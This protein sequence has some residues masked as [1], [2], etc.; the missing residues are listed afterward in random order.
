MATIGEGR[1][2]RVCDA[3]GGVDD[4][5]RHALM[6]G[7]FPDPSPE[8]VG[9]VVDNAP[10]DQRNRL[11][12]ELMDTTAIDLHLDCC[13]DRGCPTGQCGARTEGVED[14]RDG[15]LLNHLNGAKR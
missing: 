8:I 14:L 11:I 3:C 9:L 13:R 12:A 15:K 1:L 10:Q 4:S 7:D 5:P 2:L 6:S